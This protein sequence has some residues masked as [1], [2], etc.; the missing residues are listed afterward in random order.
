[1]MKQPIQSLAIPGMDN[2][3]AERAHAQGEQLARDLTA[4]M[5]TPIASIEARAGEMEQRS[6]LFIGTDANPNN[7]LF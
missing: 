2:C 3:D 1:M 6:P 7:F 5:R 4:L